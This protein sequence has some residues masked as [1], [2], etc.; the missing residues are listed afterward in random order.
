MTRSKTK[1]DRSSGPMTRSKTKQKNKIS[2]TLSNN[3]K[4]SQN[5]KRSSKSTNKNKNTNKNKSKNKKT[6]TPKAR[7]NYVTT[8]GAPITL[9]IAKLAELPINTQ[10]ETYG[11]VVCVFPQVYHR[12]YCDKKTDYLHDKDRYPDSYN[13]FDSTYLTKISNKSNTK[14]KGGVKRKNTQIGKPKAKKQKTKHFSATAS[15][16]GSSTATGF[17]TASKTTGTKSWQSPMHAKYSVNMRL[18]VPTITFERDMLCYYQMPKFF[19]M[20]LG[21]KTQLYRFRTCI[22]PGKPIY[23]ATKDNIIT[24]YGGKLKYHY[25]YK[26]YSSQIKYPDKEEWKVEDQ[27]T[28]KS[29]GVTFTDGIHRH[30]ANITFHY[31]ATGDVECSNYVSYLKEVGLRPFK[32]Y[33]AFVK[34]WCLEKYEM[35]ASEKADPDFDLFEDNMECF[36]Y[37]AYCLWCLDRQLLIQCCLVKNYMNNYNS[38]DEIDEN[39]TILQNFASHCPITG[40]HG[41][42]EVAMKYATLPQYIDKLKH[43]GVTKLCIYVCVCL[44]FL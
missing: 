41:G 17:T 13:S 2:P 14:K 36:Y 10:K 12:I 4:I 29:S 16:G 6:T 22:G 42:Y 30:V 8:T 39:F 7:H 25:I 33:V 34:Y 11:Y 38:Q 20:R 40:T 23:L 27:G 26:D 28:T 18:Y 19:N 21:K 1:L 9:T 31:R 44:K 37:I 32:Y 5:T 35:S 24:P 43:F 15:I 3:S